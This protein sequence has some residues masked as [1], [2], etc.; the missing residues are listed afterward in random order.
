MTVELGIPQRQKD[1]VFLV[2]GGN[3][4]K[5]IGGAITV[6]LAQEGASDIFILSRSP[7]D[8]VIDQIVPL[9]TRGIWVPCDISDEE[10]TVQA[11]DQ[12]KAELDTIGR[13]LNGL[14]NNAGITEKALGSDCNY[15]DFIK[16]EHI[17]K[18]F[19]TNYIGPRMLTA[20]I[21]R[22]DLFD[23]VDPD[24]EPT[25]DQIPAIVNMSSIRGRYWIAMGSDYDASKAALIT[26]TKGITAS[27]LTE[28]EYFIRANAEC[29][30]FILTDQTADIPPKLA[31]MIRR[32]TPLKRFGTPEEVAAD[33]SY[34]L[35]AE[36]GFKTGTVSAL[37]G[38]LG[39][40]VSAP[41]M[42]YM[43]EGSDI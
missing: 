19:Q 10:S 15:Y 6:L 41:I 33:V 35:S 25:P 16:R 36:A 39:G 30:G 34:L 22:R 11:V 38:G 29:P 8:E 32:A 3:K 14:V 24:G 13:R 27:V 17:E 26:W 42:L 9:G 5:A 18:M 28:Y 12:V 2:T 40:G 1:K 31:E 43:S 37:D 4:R 20:H 23:H 21:L 7:A